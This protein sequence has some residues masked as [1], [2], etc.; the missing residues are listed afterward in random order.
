MDGLISVRKVKE[1]GDVDEDGNPIELDDLE[2]E[3]DGG[4]GDEALQEPRIVKVDEEVKAEVV[5]E[6]RVEGEATIKKRAAKGQ[7]KKAKKIKVES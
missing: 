4:V 6:M 2:K 3:G 5:E 7:G 1:T